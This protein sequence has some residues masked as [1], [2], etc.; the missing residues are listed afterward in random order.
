MKVGEKREIR[1]EG[2]LPGV[3]AL[4]TKQPESSLLSRA[5]ASVAGVAESHPKEGSGAQGIC[6]YDFCKI[7][8]F[9]YLF[10]VMLI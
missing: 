1:K 7:F 10:N 9:L 6:G 5:D 4:G 8:H 2:E 3:D